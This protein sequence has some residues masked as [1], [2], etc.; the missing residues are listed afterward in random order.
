MLFQAEN[1]MNNSKIA[2]NINSQTETLNKHNKN[3][4][5][6]Q[7]LQTLFSLLFVDDGISAFIFF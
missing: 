7:L 3:S 5:N 4:K 6:Y 2:F 1:G